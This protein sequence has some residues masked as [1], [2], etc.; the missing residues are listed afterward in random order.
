MKKQRI[1]Q[2]IV[3]GLLLILSCIIALSG[4]QASLNDQKNNFEYSK[5][6]TNAENFEYHNGEYLLKMF[7]EDIDQVIERLG[8]TEDD[9]EEL[10]QPEAGVYVKLKIPVQY[11]G[12]DFDFY[13]C[14]LNVVDQ[15]KFAG[16][17]YRTSF[18]IGQEE[19]LYNAM[20]SLFVA[21][22][23]QYG[24]G[25]TQ[26]FDMNF[27]EKTSK[28]KFVNTIG[29]KHFFHDWDLETV[30]TYYIRLEAVP[31]IAKEGLSRYDLQV[32]VGLGYQDPL[33]TDYSAIEEQVKKLGS[34][35][36]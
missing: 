21:L 3:T 36:K 18:S 1:K 19:D 26:E 13:L 5:Q 11:Q 35:S 24:E 15:S 16:T 30:D 12:I 14:R 23:S 34:D 2:T 4:C 33:R 25:D 9:L 17:I 10:S 7:F 20:N 29:Q 31:V 6:A 8:Y 32:F 22:G 28:E 27:T